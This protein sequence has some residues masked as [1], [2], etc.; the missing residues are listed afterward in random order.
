MLELTGPNGALHPTA[1]TQCLAQ[2]RSST[3]TP[4]PRAG[5]TTRRQAKN[6][7]S[8]ELL[9]V[10]S[11]RLE[12]PTFG[13]ELGTFGFVAS[14]VCPPLRCSVRLFLALGRHAAP[15]RPGCSASSVA[16][17]RFAPLRD[18]A[19]AATRPPLRSVSPQRQ[20]PPYSAPPLRPNVSSSSQTSP[21][22]GQTSPAPKLRSPNPTAL[23]KPTSN[24]SFEAH[25][26]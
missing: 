9:D 8:Q 23:L 12:L 16:P 1:H 22:P 10:V 15:L 18:G 11:L 17:F 2:P 7:G 5:Q 6:G 13:L 24:S 21:A 14:D 4:A 25:L 19:G 20:K 3:V 26:Q